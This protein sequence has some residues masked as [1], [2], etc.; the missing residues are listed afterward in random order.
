M[1]KEFVNKLD[2]NRPWRRK[3]NDLPLGSVGRNV[4]ILYHFSVNLGAKC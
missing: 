1:L 4:G 2:I 3:E